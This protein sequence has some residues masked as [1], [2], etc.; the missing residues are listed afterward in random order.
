MIL[1]QLKWTQVHQN[2]PLALECD[3]IWLLAL[4]ERISAKAIEA[5]SYLDL[6][7]SRQMPPKGETFKLP[8]MKKKSSQINWNPADEVRSDVPWIFSFVHA[9]PKNSSFLVMP[10]YPSPTWPSNK[11]FSILLNHQR[12]CSIGIALKYHPNFESG[13]CM[14]SSCLPHKVLYYQNRTSQLSLSSTLSFTNNH[15]LYAFNF[16]KSFSVA[17]LSKKIRS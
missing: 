12:L 17:A 16:A 7:G 15:Y 8:G 3:E 2:V 10:L 13:V 5:R 6:D 14:P 4:P 1:N 11:E 9:I